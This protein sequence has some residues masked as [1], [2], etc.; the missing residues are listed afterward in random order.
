MGFPSTTLIQIGA[1]KSAIARKDTLVTMFTVRSSPRMNIEL[2]PT[3]TRVN[4]AGARWVPR[5]LAQY[6][7]SCHCSA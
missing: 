3:P 6:R 2:P 4:P 1:D 5:P 7:D